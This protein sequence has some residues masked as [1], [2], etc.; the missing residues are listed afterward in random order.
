MT[1]ASTT[2][3][4]PDDYPTIQE[5]IDKAWN[6]D[7]IYVK[8]GV[9]YENLVINKR[10]LLTGE[11]KYSTIID[12]K[13]INTTIFINSDRVKIKD[14]TIQN[15][16]HGI[17][18]ERFIEDTVITNNIIKDN[19]GGISLMPRSN[20][21][22]LEYNIVT[23]NIGI[24]ISLYWS[25][26]NTLRNNVLA[27]NDYNF[28]LSG[29]ISQSEQ[30]LHD[31]DTSNTVNGQPIYYWI[32]E[33]NKKIPEDAG[34]VVLVFCE[35]ITVENLN[36]ENNYD[37]VFVA[38]TK[39][40]T[41]RH[42]NMTNN[43]RGIF[44]YAYS[45]NNTIG[46]NN[47]TDNN[48]GIAIAGDVINNTI[49]GNNITD[50]NEGI[51]FSDRCTNNTIYHNNFIKNTEQVDFEATGYAN[52]WD[53]GYPSGG[54]YWSDYNGRDLN[55]DGIGEIPYVINENNQDNYPLMNPIK[56]STSAFI[57]VTDIKSEPW[58]Q[59]EIP[60]ANIDDA[61]D[62]IEN[63]ETNGKPEKDFG[64]ISVDVELRNTGL[65]AAENVMIEATISGTVALVSLD[66]NDI[67]NDYV[68]LHPFDYL[69]SY[70]V[71]TIDPSETK[72][73]TLEIPVKYACVFAGLFKYNEGDEIDVLFCAV[74]LN[75][76]ME[77]SG[78]NT[79]TIQESIGLTSIVNPY[80]LTGYI[81]HGILNRL[82][83]K[84]TTELYEQIIQYVHTISG[85]TIPTSFEIT[86]N[87]QTINTQIEPGTTSF[88][89]YAFIPDALSLIEL[90]VQV[91][92]ITIGAITT[93]AINGLAF[94]IIQPPDLMYSNDVQITIQTG[95]TT[96]AQLST[97]NSFEN[98]TLFTT[99]IL[100][101]NIHFDFGI[102]IENKTY[103]V[104]F[105]TNV[106]ISNIQ[107]NKTEKTISFEMTNQ[108]DAV[109]FFNVTIPNELLDGSL[110]VC[111]DSYC[112]YPVVILM[113]SG[114]YS[115]VYYTYTQLYDTSYEVVIKG[116]TV[117]PE[118]PS[119]VILLLPMIATLLA[120]ILRKKKKPKIPFLFFLVLMSIQY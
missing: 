81:L 2:I 38:F 94:L 45:K 105:N 80:D 41:I 101:E 67:T 44:L 56:Y 25:S 30:F 72:T 28:Y 34:V 63:F 57:E 65:E 55:G 36:L 49:V 69:Y 58:N 24:G 13:G 103:Y 90:T 88:S 22:T 15:G 11:D 50:N 18:V 78:T 29:H 32:Y 98:F 43:H 47:I 59:L 4:V 17:Y 39:N 51:W 52:L 104:H 97:R 48:E 16:N 79:N 33:A 68:Y 35:N 76:D 87:T 42:N 114:T 54:N 100:S 31:I 53:N 95:P 91:G 83:D 117:I 12:G 93:T 61:R 23:N 70:P 10:L 106:S 20:N 7:T 1:N 64:T 14:L 89:V 110:S 3:T 5:A 77:I 109:G 112:N 116:T 113:G 107:F 119:L 84:M 66:E 21:N 71:G 37:G 92:A 96:L 62:Y 102:P 9:Y 60:F 46:G 74:E 86:A 8:V 108:I 82:K 73:A 40:A 120:A 111:I 85:G 26:H 19:S 118:F 99:S 115:W 6:G 75:V 27:D